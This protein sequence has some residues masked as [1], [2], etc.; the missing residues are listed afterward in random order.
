MAGLHLDPAFADHWRYNAMA[1]MYAL[2]YP[3]LRR[4]ARTIP[5]VPFRGIEKFY[6]ISG[7]LAH[8][9]TTRYVVKYLAILVGM[10]HPTVIA[11]VD[12]RGF[13]LGPLIARELGLPFVM[14]RKTGKLPNAITATAEYTKEYTEVHGEDRLCVTDGLL[15]PE[16]RVAIVDDLAAT[17]GTLVAAKNLLEQDVGTQVVACAVLVQ[18]QHLNAEQKLGDCPLVSLLRESL[19]ADNVTLWGEESTVG[20]PCSAE[21]HCETEEGTLGDGAQATEGDIP[22]SACNTQ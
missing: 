8:P 17:G 13:I 22:A 11:G 20:S 15:S 1:S 3:E 7:L 2:C 12:A 5:C 16:D 14:I 18:I 9:S 4:V 10:Y 6:D 21:V 19:W